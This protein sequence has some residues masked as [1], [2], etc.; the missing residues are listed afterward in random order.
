MGIVK[1]I[2]LM[3]ILLRSSGVNVDLQLLMNRWWYFKMKMH[4][5]TKLIAADGEEVHQLQWSA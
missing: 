1:I 5:S 4:S 3:Q 2:T